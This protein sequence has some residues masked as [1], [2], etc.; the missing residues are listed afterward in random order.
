MTPHHITHGMASASPP[1]R[2]NNYEIGKQI[3]S[4]SFSQVYRCINTVNHAEFAMKI[5]PKSNLS[6]PGDL[7]RFQ[8]EVNIMAYLKH[9]NL[10]ALHDFFWDDTNFYLAIDLCPGGDLFTYLIE[11]SCIDETT[12][13]IVFYQIVSAIEYC[14]SCSI[15]HRDIKPENILITRFPHIKV[16]DFGLTGLI[17]QGTLLDTFCGSPCYLPPECLAGKKY[18]GRKSD[19]WSLA[20]VLYAMTTGA[21]PWHSENLPRMVQQIRRGDFSISDLL[22]PSCRDLVES[23]LKV[24]PDDRLDINEVL[25]HPWLKQAK[26]SRLVRSNGRSCADSLPA[27]RRLSMEDVGEKLARESKLSSS[28]IVS[29]FD[30]DEVSRSTGLPKLVTNV[31]SPTRADLGLTPIRSRRSI[32]ASGCSP[33][34]Q[35][36]PLLL[37]GKTK[38][39]EPKVGGQDVLSE[40]K[41]EQAEPFICHR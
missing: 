22:S 38:V 19:V 25:A 4:G 10:V 5:F 23:M 36:S 12:A 27:A 6:E 2:I 32:G 39:V 35:R 14:H 41:G 40:P 9:D 33:P 8:R 17:H 21:F 26:H 13:A 29:P 34:R 30:P 7:D 20:V 11:N 31:L 24:N 16:A 28:G 3:G 1:Q 37:L 18:D 15:A